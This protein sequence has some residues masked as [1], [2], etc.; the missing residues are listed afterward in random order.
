MKCLTKDAKVALPYQYYYIP[1]L[2][3][4]LAGIS[5]TIFLS[6]SHYRNYTDIS[7]ASFCAI[8]KAINCDTVSQSPWSILFN[9][10]VAL[11]GLIGYLLFFVIL[12]PVRKNTEEARTLWSILFVLALL[13]TLTAVFFGYISANKIHSYC[14]LC[15]LS[16][17]ISF[18]LFLYSWIIRRRFCEGSLFADLKLS[19]LNIRRNRYLQYALII[20]FV[21]AFILKVFTPHYWQYQFSEPGSLLPSGITEDGY[22]WIGATKPTLTIEEFSDYQCFQCAKMHHF[23]R[24]LVADSPEKIRLVHRNYPMDNEFNKFV[25]PEPF[26]VGSGLLALAA[27]AAE[28]QNKFWEMNDALYAIV[29]EKQD[30]INLITL[31]EENG[32]DS[33]LLKRDMY[34]Q[35]SLKKLQKDIWQGLRYNITGTPTFVI[36]GQVFQGG[37]PPAILKY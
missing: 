26:H 36:D 31:A 14:L 9:I 23:L 11:W 35:E 21:F 10:P 33:E 28:K 18:L 27:I 29:S 25:V 19:F 20:L 30:K 3:L 4:T 2:L 8:S 24:L 34:D 16:Y 13:Y 22:P 1:T 5:D 12:I 17:G 37:I 6:L 32:I 7:Y 15:L